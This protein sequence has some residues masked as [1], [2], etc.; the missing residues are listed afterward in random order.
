MSHED[1][2]AAVDGMNGGS[3]RASA[4]GWTKIGESLQQALNDF[5]D[6]I[7]TE[8]DGK[9]EGVAKDS[10]TAATGRYATESGKLAEAGTLIGTKITEAA[11]GVDQVK[12]TVP[13]VSKRSLLEVAFD[14][15]MPTAGLFKRLVHDQDEAHQEAIQIMRTVYTPVMQ[16]ADT[17]VPR[18]PEP[19][20]VIGPSQSRPESGG[21]V[22]GTGTPGTPTTYTGGPNTSSQMPQTSTAD[23]PLPGAAPGG[24]S[25]PNSYNPITPPSNPPPTTN[26][27]HRRT[28]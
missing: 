22:P 8:T 21:S 18:L 9:W 11:T 2:K 15:G 3:L 10:A 7:T 1:I 5:R 23:G 19:P 27:P 17:N 6:F 20:T 26:S 24:G 4:E 12:A 16:Q 14:A 13:P 25:T 28:P